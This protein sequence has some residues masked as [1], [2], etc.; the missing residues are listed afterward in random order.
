MSTFSGSLENLLLA[1]AGRSI[2]MENVFQTQVSTAKT[3]RV[4]RAGFILSRLM[5]IQLVVEERRSF[6]LVRL[7]IIVSHRG[8]V[9]RVKQLH[10]TSRSTPIVQLPSFKHGLVR[11]AV[12]RQRTMGHSLRR[13]THSSHSLDLRTR[14]QRTRI[15]TDTCNQTL[16]SVLLDIDHH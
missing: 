4:F 14:C 13:I 12:A 10:F 8:P 3:T 15:D 16:H 11:Q 5:T 7:P 9:N 6:Q 2:R 1:N